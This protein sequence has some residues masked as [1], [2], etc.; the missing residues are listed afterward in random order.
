MSSTGIESHNSKFQPG[1]L[2]TVMNIKGHPYKNEVL[3]LIQKESVDRHGADVWAAFSN[4]RNRM[5]LVE[6]SAFN[7]QTR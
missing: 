4:K 2:V 7:K 1:D 6:T 5:I 3:Q